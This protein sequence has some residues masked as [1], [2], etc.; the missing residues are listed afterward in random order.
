MPI[1]I[2]ALIQ[3]WAIAVIGEFLDMDIRCLKNAA[4]RIEVLQSII[5][6]TIFKPLFFQLSNSGQVDDVVPE[7]GRSVSCRSSKICCITWS[8]IDQEY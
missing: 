6:G 3:R 5:K 2:N 7:D 1:S 4:M 8:R